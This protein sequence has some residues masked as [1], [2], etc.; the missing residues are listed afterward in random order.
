[1]SLATEVSDRR[2]DERWRSHP[3]SDAAEPIILCVG[4]HEPRKNQDAVLF[5]AEML[6]REGLDF[7]IVFVG[8]GSRRPRSDSTA[9]WRASRRRAC[10]SSR[11]RLGDDELWT[12]YSQA[13]FSV[14]ASLHEG[15]G[16][17]VAESLALGT[18][19]LTSDFGSLERGRRPKAAACRSTRGTTRRSSTACRTLLLDDALLRSPARP[20]SPVTQKTWKT[21]ADELWASWRTAKESPHE[22]PH[23]S[24]RP[25]DRAVRAPPAPSRGTVARLAPL[26]DGARLVPELSPAGRR[27]P[28]R[29]CGVPL[30]RLPRTAASPRE[31]QIVDVHAPWR[32]EGSRR[33]SA[34][35]TPPCRSGAPTT[36]SS[37]AGLVID[38]T[39]TGRSRF[40]TGIQRV[41]RARRSPGGPATTGC[42]SPAVVTGMTHLRGDS[43]EPR[44]TRVVLEPAVP[45]TVVRH[46]GCRRR[47]LRRRPSCFPR[48]PSLRVAGRPPPRHRPLQPQSA[49]PP[50]A[51]TASRSR[52][53]RPPAPACRA[54]SRST[55]RLSARSTGS[56]RSRRR[57]RPSTRDGAGCSG[58]QVSPAPPSRRCRCPAAPSGWTTRSWSGP[59][60]AS[61]SPT[62]RSCSPSAAT[63]R[64]RT[65]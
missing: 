14:F 50:S 13:R 7:R 41:A 43:D 52:P 47:A 32:V 8:G 18:P 35:P 61:A 29:E 45:L 16:L 40:T 46:L 5:A 55:S 56:R 64:G 31:R 27:P 60:S 6:F 4:S 19:V 12:F 48:S 1:M 44:S 39:D 15:F 24:S 9:A 21:Y 33:P 28:R 37:R 17:P 30:P 11:T 49:P 57:A 65:T 63:N 51:S 36:S 22:P 53:P 26:V 34:T 59:P 20:R 2:P 42:A 23:A 58:E 3:R 38:V 54:P 25:R 10:A 62:R